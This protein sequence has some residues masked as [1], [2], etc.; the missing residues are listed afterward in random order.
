MVIYFLYDVSGVWEAQIDE[1][2]LGLRRAELI[3]L[4]MGYRDGEGNIDVAIH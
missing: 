1:G 4:D 3:T 2:D